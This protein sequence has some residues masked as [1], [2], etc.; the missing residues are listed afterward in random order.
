MIA[1]LAGGNIKQQD[2]WSHHPPRPVP[3]LTPRP[4]GSL[5]A[6][7]GLGADELD[8]TWSH[9][10]PTPVGATG[11]TGAAN[12]V[13]GCNSEASTP[14]SRARR[15]AV[16]WGIDPAPPADPPPAST[17]RQQRQAAT[18]PPR[19]SALNGQH[20]AP[21]APHLLR[22]PLGPDLQRSSRLELHGGV[23]DAPPLARGSAS[24]EQHLCRRLIACRHAE[25]AGPGSPR[26]KHLPTMQRRRWELQTWVSDPSETPGA[27]SLVRRRD[28]DG[29]GGAG[30]GEDGRGSDHMIT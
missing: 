7:A 16:P 26:P 1:S 6:L 17:R 9:C 29:G 25:E 20:E 4:R 27:L 12:A 22:P 28:A 8:S 10:P 23:P 21:S 30:G 14:R 24:E 15:L 2:T 19:I 3:R 13:A 5:A 18:L 11:A